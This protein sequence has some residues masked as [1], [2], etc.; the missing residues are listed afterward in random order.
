MSPALSPGEH[1]EPDSGLRPSEAAMTK[2]A[3]YDE[4]GRQLGVTAEAELVEAQRAEAIRVLLEV[5]ATVSGILASVTDMN[6]LKALDAVGASLIE[7]GERLRGVAAQFV[8]DAL[9]ADAAE[10]DSKKI[11]SAGFEP[12][13]AC[14]TIGEHICRPAEGSPAKEPLVFSGGASVSANSYFEDLL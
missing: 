9:L 13:P 6:T 4:L 7:E 14:G 10:S 1:T 12:C 8:E 5:I 3:L 2:R 11:R